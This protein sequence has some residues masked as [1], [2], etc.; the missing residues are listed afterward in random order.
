MKSDSN[1][2]KCLIVAVSYR[3]VDNVI[4]TQEVRRIIQILRV[5][6]YCTHITDKPDIDIVTAFKF[7]GRTFVPWT[8]AALP[9]SPLP[10]E[11]P[12]SNA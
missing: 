10:P 5:L 9:L 3:L 2:E 12:P 1:G 8:F 11:H 4:Y 7:E 6:N